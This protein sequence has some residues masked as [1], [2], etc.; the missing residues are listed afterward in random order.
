MVSIGQYDYIIQFFVIKTWLRVIDLKLI[1]SFCLKF[2]SWSFVQNDFFCFTWIFGMKLVTLESNFKESFL[3]P[4]EIS[5]SLKSIS[6]EVFAHQVSEKFSV[7]ILRYLT[8]KFEKI[9]DFSAQQHL[10]PP[11]WNY[12]DILYIWKSF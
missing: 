4:R 5:F 11:L 3:N 1:R 7:S 6:F 9:R 10:W 8:L 2:K 12:S